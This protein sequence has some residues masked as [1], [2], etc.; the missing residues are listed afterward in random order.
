MVK[1][2]SSCLILLFVVQ[3][4]VPLDCG[5]PNYSP[6][7]REEIGW[8]LRTLPGLKVAEINGED[9][10]SVINFESC[11]T[12]SSNYSASSQI[13]CTQG[14]VLTKLTNSS[15]LSSINRPTV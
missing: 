5:S 9:S 7:Q 15:C 12:E 1:K 3:W 2:T 11:A 13:V 6:A 10:A 8:W 14:Q 4:S